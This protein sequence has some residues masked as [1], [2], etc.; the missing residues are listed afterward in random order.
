M[1]SERWDRIEDIFHCALQV[2]VTDREAFLTG[3]CGGDTNLQ[4]EVQSLI[5]AY[6]LP[7]DFLDHTQL[8]AGLN[9]YAARDSQTLA[10]EVIGPYTL[11]S[12]IGRGGM[13]DVYLAR[14]ERLGRS[15]ALKVLPTFMG[16]DSD[17][18]A[19]FRQ[20]ARAASSIS[21]PNIAHIYE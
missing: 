12:R 18:I 14:D 17:W 2:A 7:G 19:R 8:S 1:K 11:E 21:H 16:K 10:G 4:Q 5:S 6:E 20:E 3:A 13:G 9:L 15:V